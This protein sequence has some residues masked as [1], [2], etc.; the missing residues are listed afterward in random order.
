MAAGQVLCG[1]A[2]RA[3][4]TGSGGGGWARRVRCQGLVQQGP[5]QLRRA[6]GLR[7]PAAVCAAD[8]QAA[9]VA[10]EH[11]AAGQGQHDAVQEDPQQA[12]QDAALQ[13]L[14]KVMLGADGLRWEARG[15]RRGRQASEQL[16]QAWRAS[17][18]QRGGVIALQ[19]GG[20]PSQL[21]VLSP[22]NRCPRQ[23]S[24]AA[25]GC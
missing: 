6:A 16:Q 8:K 5:K 20:L 25:A 23:S 3:A 24:P 17:P 11:E 7:L 4:C 18:G 15:R 12:Q 9:H 13:R 1:P 19:P 10:L 21:T 14:L 2:S 22:S